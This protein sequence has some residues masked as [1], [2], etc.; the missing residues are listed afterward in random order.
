[1]PSASNPLNN[2]LESPGKHPQETT[3][4]A[5]RPRQNAKHDTGHEECDP[6]PL[7]DGAPESV[8][9]LSSQPSLPDTIRLLLRKKNLKPLAR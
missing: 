3:Q 2:R 7:A 6:E 5:Q 9:E 4:S 1:M 8:G